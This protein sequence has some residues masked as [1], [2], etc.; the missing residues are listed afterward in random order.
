MCEWPHHKPEQCCICS[1]PVL[2]IVFLKSLV[3]PLTVKIVLNNAKVLTYHSNLTELCFLYTIA[4]KNGRISKTSASGGFGNRTIL[5]IKETTS[6]VMS[7]VFL[8][9]GPK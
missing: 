7:L 3:Q 9:S 6:H 2:G 1:T 4:D 5:F 8:T